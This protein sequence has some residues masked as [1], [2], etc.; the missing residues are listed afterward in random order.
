VGGG[1]L[2]AGRACIRKIGNAAPFL[3]GT[4]SKIQ[5]F[6]LDTRRRDANCKPQVNRFTRK[7]QIPT[8]ISVVFHH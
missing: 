4:F 1:I 6:S 3:N 2:R 7:I 5:A 8:G